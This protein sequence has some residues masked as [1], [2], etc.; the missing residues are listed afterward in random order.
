[1]IKV[2]QQYCHLLVTIIL[3]VVTEYNFISVISAK[4]LKSN[5]GY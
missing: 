4:G 1:M 2:K 3:I 5:T